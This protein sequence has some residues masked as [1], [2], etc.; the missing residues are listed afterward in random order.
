MPGRHWFANLPAMLEIVLIIAVCVLMAKIAVQS[1]ANGGAW[2]AITAIICGLC[3]LI[4]VPFGRILV[5][6][7]LSFVAL[8]VYKVRQ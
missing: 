2:A 5:A 7:I 8:T 4:P 3:L 1:D 6:A